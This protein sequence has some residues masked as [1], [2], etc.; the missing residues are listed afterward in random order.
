[1]GERWTDRTSLHLSSPGWQALGVIY[2]DLVHVLQVPDFEAATG[3]LARI[4]WSRTGPLWKE[5]VLERTK[6]DGTV[7]FVL[8]SAGA[9]N[10]RLMI[11]TLRERLSI[12]ERVHQAL[13]A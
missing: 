4:D 11:K 10:R 5:L 12:A 2:H 9:N 3:A 13:A 6:D 7:E 1:M 8:G